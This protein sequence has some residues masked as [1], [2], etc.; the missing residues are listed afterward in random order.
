MAEAAPRP[1]RAAAILG[2]VAEAAFLLNLAR[3]AKL[4]F[5]E[6]HYVRAARILRSLAAPFNTEHPLFAKTIIAAGISV[7]GDN[8]FVLGG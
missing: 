5:D 6:V 7:F 3:P 2:I 4:V 8:A 1:Y